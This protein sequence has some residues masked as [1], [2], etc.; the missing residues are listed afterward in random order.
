NLPN[1]PYNIETQYSLPK[2][3]ITRDL[4]HRFFENQMQINGGKNDKMAAWAD[5]GGLVMGYWDATG[6]SLGQLAKQFVLADNF[7]QGAFGGSFLNHQY[8]I[9]ACAPEYAN[10][11]VAAAHPSIAVVD[12]DASGK[13]T[14]SLT[15]T[16]ASP[17]SSLDG[18]PLFV[19]SGNIAPKNYFGDGT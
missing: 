2:T 1:K 18:I 14:S 19:L 11:D 16:S 12:T 17:A 13:M 6:T 7:F 5:S 4:Y 8:L 10:A 15:R 3:I 9:C